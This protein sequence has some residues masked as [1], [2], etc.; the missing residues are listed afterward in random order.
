MDNSVQCPAYQNYHVSLFRIGGVNVDDGDDGRPSTLSLVLA[1]VAFVMM[2]IF[3][4]VTLFLIS[5]SKGGIL[6]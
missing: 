5:I 4:L 3:V 6:W 1:S 2:C